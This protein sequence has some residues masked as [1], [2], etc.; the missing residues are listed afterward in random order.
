MTRLII[1]GRNRDFPDDAAQSMAHLMPEH[2]GYGFN[3]IAFRPGP[4]LEAEL[5]RYMRER[6][7]FNQAAAI[8]S[9]LA[10]ALAS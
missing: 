7:I 3:K 5:T 6:Q 9:L 1:T 10:K 8:R 4:A 2:G